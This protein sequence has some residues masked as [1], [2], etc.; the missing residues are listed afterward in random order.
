MANKNNKQIKGIYLEFGV[1]KGQSINFFS[2]YVDEIFGFDSFEG[3][4]EDWL[5]HRIIAGNYS[6]NKKIPKLKPN[7]IPVKG[8][9][10]DTLV[11]F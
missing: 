1:F 6:L 8:W 11:K 4:K 3:L 10:Q 5:G 7:V 2:N 9:I